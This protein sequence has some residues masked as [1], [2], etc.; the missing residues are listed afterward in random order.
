MTELPSE[1]YVAA[2]DLV[3]RIKQEIE[4]NSIV[5]V[6]SKEEAQT[7]RIM[8]KDREAFGRVFSWLI[9]VVGG[10]ATIFAGWSVISGYWNK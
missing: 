3:F 2:D 1:K 8:I 4:D 7:L 9:Y 6:L 10:A 5:L